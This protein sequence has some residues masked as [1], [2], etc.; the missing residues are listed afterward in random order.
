MWKPVGRESLKEIARDDGI[1]G[2]GRYHLL[3]VDERGAVKACSRDRLPLAEALWLME[4]LPLRVAMPGQG[5]LWREL[6]EAGRREDARE[7]GLRVE[8]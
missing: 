1:C 4:R 2:G 3:V 8:V 6:R 7:H 5:E